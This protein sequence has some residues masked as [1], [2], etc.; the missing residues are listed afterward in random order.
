V[1]VSTGSHSGETIATH[2]CCWGG[3]AVHQSPYRASL[4]HVRWPCDCAVRR[5]RGRGR[6]HLQPP[7]GRSRGSRWRGGGSGVGGSRSWGRETAGW[8]PTG[9]QRARVAVVGARGDCL[10]GRE[11]VR[12]AQTQSWCKRRGGLGAL[13]A[14]GSAGGGGM[15]SRARLWRRVRRKRPAR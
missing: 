5:A 2:S 11:G 13:E 1:S 10:E 14:R 4:R 6:S 3:C 8:S 12:W 15:A 7:C 9:A